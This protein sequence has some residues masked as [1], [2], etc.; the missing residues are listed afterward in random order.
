MSQ[1]ELLK[2]AL[3]LAESLG[4]SQAEVA[5]AV[6]RSLT[7]TFE[8]NSIKDIEEGFSSHFAVRV[9]IGKSLGISTATPI[10][11]ENIENAVKRAISLAKSSPP[12]EN[13]V[14]LPSDAKVSEVPG[15]YDPSF[16]EVS[17]EDLI[18]KTWSGMEAARSI[19]K[20]IDVS[21]G[22]RASVAEA[23]ILNSL[24]VERSMKHSVLYFGIDAQK[25]VS[26]E[27]IGIGYDYSLS[28]TLKGLNFEEVGVKAANKAIRSV[29]AKKVKSGVYTLILDERTT[30][31]TIA[32]IVGHGAN[33]FNILQKTSYYLGKLG[34]KVTSE[35][36][37]VKDDP[38]YPYGWR[39]S[40]FDSEG[41]PSIQVEIVKNGIL[42]SYIT[43]SYTAN[44]LK[45][46]NNGHA[47]RGDLSD[48]PRPGLTNVQISPGDY[49][50]E[51]LFKEVK[52]GI[53]IYDS[54]LSPTG[55]TTNI[56]SLVDQ[57]FLIENG[58]IKNP[59]KN[60][61][62]GSTVFDLLNSV[63]AVGKKVINEGGSISPKIRIRNV[64]IA[65]E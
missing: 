36:I 48:K 6:G 55:G 58:E 47:M 65:G 18:N 2:K 15:L 53:Y 17:S 60:T 41:Y 40:P 31:S 44:A 30:L 64:R 27:D 50:D 24:G 57:G 29:G 32:S 34:S 13:F 49:E 25:K 8:K 42:K 22:T 61:M 21:G 56:S 19:D 5:G 38:L 63:D 62:V 4:A 33:A 35:L 51:E 45:I 7:I 28:R 12:D 10:S 11:E 59:V 20:S 3:K 43:D 26:S 46:E 16:E 14:S 52:L 1:L 54:S 37:S 39:S 9:Y 23:F